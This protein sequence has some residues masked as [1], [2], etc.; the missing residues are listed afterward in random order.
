MAALLA[1]S[2]IIVPSAILPG[3]LVAPGQGNLQPTLDS[4]A[5]ACFRT[6]KCTGKK[7][8]TGRGVGGG[9]AGVSQLS[10]AFVFMRWAGPH[11]Q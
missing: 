6:D 9:W 7:H 2:V 3:P 1:A 8:L 5:A 4:C 10:V 11:A